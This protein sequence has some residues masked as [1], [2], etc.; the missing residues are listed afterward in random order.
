[1]LIKRAVSSAE[2]VAYVGMS[3]DDANCFNF[4]QT[5]AKGIEFVF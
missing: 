3:T 5:I 1:M 4:G 2:V